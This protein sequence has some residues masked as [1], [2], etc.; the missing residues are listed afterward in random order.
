MNQPPDV[1]PR[2]E[3][4]GDDNVVDNKEKSQ[5][6]VEAQQ[7]PLFTTSSSSVE[8]LEYVEPL[9]AVTTITIPRTQTIL[10]GYSSGASSLDLSEHAYL[11]EDEEAEGPGGD[12][13]SSSQRRIMCP[14]AEPDHT[15]NRPRAQSKQSQILDLSNLRQE[16][17]SRR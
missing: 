17:G 9:K 3:E 6:V 8:E 4:D 10:P 16:N 13:G 15:P 1:A 12:Y 2:R 7:P 14:A 11:L 5:Q